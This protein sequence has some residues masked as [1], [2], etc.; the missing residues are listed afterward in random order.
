[1]KTQWKSYFFY[2]IRIIIGGS[3]LFIVIETFKAKN[4]G[5][6]TKTLWDWMELLI[7]P[8]ALA[9]GA[10]YLDRSERAIEREIAT[11]RQQETALQSYIDRIADLLL[12][13]KLRTSKKGEVRDVA[14]IL[15]LTV[16]RVLDARRKGLVLL[17]LDESGL[18]RRDGIIDLREA[19]LTQ[20]ILT[21]ASLIKANLNW[22]QLQGADLRGAYLAQAYLI[23][24]NLSEANLTGADLSESL[25]DGA[26]LTK[27]DLTGA[28]LSGS[29]VYPWQL[30][31]AKSLK[32]ATMPEGTKH[33]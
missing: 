28:N 10:F 27:A 9:I 30:E 33:D 16:L 25:L 2:A 31:S 21:G 29:T 8:L 26:N 12:K 20:A 32:G 18:I 13:E 24:A 17:F 1:M 19:D 5:F 23:E 3:L 6:E 15:T 11:D 22:A 7:I 4:T 14:R